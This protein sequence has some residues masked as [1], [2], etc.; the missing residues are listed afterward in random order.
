[1]PSVKAAPIPPHI[2]MS[3]TNQGYC[4]YLF[5]NNLKSERRLD[6]NRAAVRR[7]LLSREDPLVL[8]N[9]PPLNP[10]Y[11]ETATE[12]KMMHG[13]NEACVKPKTIKK[14]LVVA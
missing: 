7:H 9:P 12:C 6:D 14:K 2:M 3:D 13:G 5:Q 4:E 10:A 8:V 11:S 1:M